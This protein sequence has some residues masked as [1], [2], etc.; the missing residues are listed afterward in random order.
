MRTWEL[1]AFHLLRPQTVFADAVLI[2][3]NPTSWV[4]RSLKPFLKSDERMNPDL[5]CIFCWP[6]HCSCYMFDRFPLR[7]AASRGPFPRVCKLVPCPL[8]IWILHWLIINHAKGLRGDKHDL[9]SIVCTC[10]VILQVAWWPSTSNHH[11]ASSSG[12]QFLSTTRCCWNSSQ[13]NQLQLRYSSHVADALPDGRV[14]VATN[15]AGSQR[16]AS[17]IAHSAAF[18]PMSF[19]PRGSDTSYSDSS[20]SNQHPAIAEP[21]PWLRMIGHRLNGHDFSLDLPTQ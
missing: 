21:C 12:L 17:R 9:D 3:V 6:C 19:Q 7:D 5:E 13:K 8:G 14:V 1:L 18:Q 20:A 15:Q 10:A 11:W 16:S 4:V 2:S